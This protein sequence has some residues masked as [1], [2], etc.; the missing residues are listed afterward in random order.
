MVRALL[1]DLD[2]TLIDRDAAHRAWVAEVA[3]AA[4]RAAWIAADDHGYRPRAD[5]FAWLAQV[6]PELGS[7]DALWT[8]YRVRLPEL[9]T[10]RPA[11]GA[12]LDRLAGRYALGLVSNG[13]GETQRRKLARAGLAAHFPRPVISGEL[14]AAKPD[15]APF[16][17][18]LIALGVSADQALYV[19]DDPRR[20]V[21][22]ARAAGLRTCWIA[23]GRAWEG[24]GAPP[25]GTIEDVL[26][27]EG[28]L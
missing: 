12:L 17:A 9:V 11:V 10:P 21:A 27:L 8:R 22:G 14:G 13:G 7:A 23:H 6:H 5:Y 2:R 3:P 24:P 4:A 19:G 15:P 26:E 16:L 18:A 28:A 20:D 1:F 25:D